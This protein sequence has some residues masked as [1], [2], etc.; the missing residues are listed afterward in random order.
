LNSHS[1]TLR[2]IINFIIYKVF[3]I[4]KFKRRWKSERKLFVSLG[5]KIDKNYPIYGDYMDQAGS[6]SGHY[7]HQDLLVA[8]FI[9]EENPKRHIDIGSRIDGF[10]AHVASFRNIEVFD[11]RHVGT[12]PHSN[13]K[14]NLSNLMDSNKINLE[15]TDSLSCLHT[16]EHFGL[17]RYGDPIDPSGHIKGFRNMAKMLES[18]GIFYISFPIGNKNQVHFNA[19]RIFN[20]VEIF[21]WFEYENQFKLVRFDYVDDLGDL[22]L[23]VELETFNSKL[24]YGCGI[25]TLIKL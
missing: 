10:V 8:N 7:F 25:Y 6:A 17:G 3:H 18:N 23:N 14:Y 12:N 11:I 24:K 13:I 21:N 9:H 4:L 5:G 22:H 15:M 20:P 2:K 1:I 19:H 16:I